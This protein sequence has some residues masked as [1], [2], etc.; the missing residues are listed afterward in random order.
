[1]TLEIN[2]IAGVAVVLA[3][4]EMVETNFVEAGRAGKCRKVSADTFGVFVGA[5][6]HGGGIPTNEGTNTTFDVFIA[7]EPRFVLARNGVHIRS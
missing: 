2:V 3:A 7:R 5:H 6:N 4:E 1:M